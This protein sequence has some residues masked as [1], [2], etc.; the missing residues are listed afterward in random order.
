MVQI[1]F[2]VAMTHLKKRRQGICGI[3]REKSG[4]W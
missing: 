4:K 3:Q 2:G 1:S